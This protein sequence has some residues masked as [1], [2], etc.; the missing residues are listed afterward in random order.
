MLAFIRKC[1]GYCVEPTALSRALQSIHDLTTQL[2]ILV[3]SQLSADPASALLQYNQLTRQ[4]EQVLRAFTKHHIAEQIRAS[5]VDASQV[6]ETLLTHE[7]WKQME[8]VYRSRPTSL[9]VPENHV[10]LEAIQQLFWTL[11]QTHPMADIR[12]TFN[13]PTCELFYH[14]WHHIP[15]KLQRADVPVLEVVN[16]LRAHLSSQAPITFT[17]LQ[18]VYQKKED[19]EIWWLATRY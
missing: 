13:H 17:S 8:R 6:P 10:R 11:Y 9:P 14:S 19:V 7:E 5:R 3:S 4:T 16:H 12:H 1:L 18:F 2:P 15:F